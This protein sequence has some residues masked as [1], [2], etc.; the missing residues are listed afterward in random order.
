MRRLAR[1]AAETFELA[2]PEGHRGFNRE[3]P[4][5][6]H[7]LPFVVVTT[8]RRRRRNLSL[9][10]E[11]RARSPGV[12]DCV[13]VPV[14]VDRRGLDSSEEHMDLVVWARDVTELVSRKARLEA[15]GFALLAEIEV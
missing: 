4:S 5:H 10:D 3:Q 12:V 11:T 8:L 14:F 9:N 15:K 2:P 6:D 13:Y 7:S 1:P